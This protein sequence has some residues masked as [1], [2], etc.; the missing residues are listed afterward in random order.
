M[1]YK[2]WVL[3]V[4]F[5]AFEKVTN[6][7][8]IILHPFTH[9]SIQIP[10]TQTGN[11]SSVNEKNWSVDQWYGGRGKEGE[12]QWM[13]LLESVICIMFLMSM[14]TLAPLLVCPLSMVTIQM[15]L[16]ERSMSF[17]INSFFLRTFLNG[18]NWTE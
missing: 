15:M 17:C 7:I 14:C 16:R 6:I 9:L 2:F 5:K 10:S 4:P 8:F 3:Q 11:S 18:Q 13:I 1:F 12:G